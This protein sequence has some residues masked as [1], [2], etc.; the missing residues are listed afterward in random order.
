MRDWHS[1]VERAP[2]GSYQQ[3]AWWALAKLTHGF[4]ARRVVISND[5]R[6]LVGAQLL[7]RPTLFG[8]FGYVPLAPILAS[9]DSGAC[10][11][12]FADMPLSEAIIWGL[13][14]V[15]RANG[16]CSLA[17]QPP[18]G[19]E[20]LARK[21]QCAGFVPAPVSLAPDATVLLDLSENLDN[22]L[23]R[24][25][26]TTRYDIRA[27]QKR[28]VSVREAL[29][30]DLESID[31][32]LTITSKRQCFHCPGKSYLREVWRH[33]A[34][35]FKGFIAEVDGH[36]VSV[37]LLTA[38]GDTVTYW[39]G[40][41][42]GEQGRLYPNEALQWAAIQ[43]AKNQNYRY[44]DFGGIPRE[45][46]ARVL[47]GK[48]DRGSLRHS[49]GFY[50]LGFGGRVELFPETFVYFYNS[51][52]RRAW[53]VLSGLDPNRIFFGVC[54]AAFPDPDFGAVNLDAELGFKC[55]YRASA[56]PKRVAPG[57]CVRFASN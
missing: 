8:A 41:W 35:H 26:K 32:I 57:T 4:R 27:S 25:S 9:Q 48:C 11:A 19:G 22:I 1:F 46:A 54:S 5:N 10:G 17:V 12:S 38:Y 36:P 28:G 43:W 42:T 44:Y 45:L 18:R 37:V 6:I 49:V 14:E 23:S 15:A 56:R 21:L 33:L 39:R 51:A 3:T 13:H 2:G 16:L 53:S 7:Y 29:I 40:G 30:T 31:Q 47:Q 50:K 34:Q 52:L 20:L 55:R 24:M